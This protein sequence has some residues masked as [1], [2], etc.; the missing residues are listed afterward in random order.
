[1]LQVVISQL[2]Q[3]NQ[4]MSDSFVRG[5]EGSGSG[6]SPHWES[7]DDDGTRDS[8]TEEGSGSGNGGVIDGMYCLKNRLTKLESSYIQ[9]PGGAHIAM[10]KS[11]LPCRWSRSETGGFDFLQYLL[12]A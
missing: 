4:L 3:T 11:V 5:E 2:S 1:M 12:G 6:H 8:W 10:F 7:D 9:V